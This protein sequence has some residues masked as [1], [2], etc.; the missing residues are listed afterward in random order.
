[1]S[2]NV[3][4]RKG[5]PHRLSNTN[6]SVISLR[7]IPPPV[8]ICLNLKAKKPVKSAKEVYTKLGGYG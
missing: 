4:R 3:K 6:L 2:V 7:I 8:F 5:K 1:M